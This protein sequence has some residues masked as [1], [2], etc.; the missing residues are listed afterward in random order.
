MM[1]VE[2]GVSM[3]RKA[4]PDRFLATRAALGLGHLGP[5][6]RGMPWVAMTGFQAWPVVIT[7]QSCRSSAAARTVWAWMGFSLLWPRL[8]RC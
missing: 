1:S 5:S 3:P 2:L 7:A 6:G 4:G 8:V